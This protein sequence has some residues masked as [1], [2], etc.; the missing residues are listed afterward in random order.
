MNNIKIALIGGGGF[1]G[2]NLANY[3]T[4]KLFNVKIISKNPINIKNFIN[5]E[6]EEINLDVN[7]T[8][9]LINSLQ[10]CQ[11]IVWLVNELVPSST[12]NSVVDDFNFSTSS[13]I[14]FLEKS[15]NLK[16]L[17]RF[18]Y[19]SSGGTI[20][21]D[22][23]HNEDFA[24]I[25]L[26]APISAYGLSKRISE[27]YIEYFSR[28]VNYKCFV[29]RPSNV[30]G[31]FQNMNRMQGIIGFAFNSILKN[32]TID[33]F[34]GGKV[35][36]DFIYVEDLA[37]AIFAVIL[38]SYPTQIIETYNIASQKPTAIF[39]VL[40]LIENVTN[41]KLNI[42]HKPARP[43]DCTYNVLDISKITADTQWQP[44]TNLSEGLQIVWDWLKMEA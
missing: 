33:L 10:D 15:G 34:G 28:K 23:Q 39:E 29:L 40:H 18:I 21:G 44:Q 9:D 41:Q 20:Y 19:L 2:T 17:Q 30:Y 13:L 12:M 8:D 36:R 22:S 43:F 3:F 5:K 37:T 32:K 4:E 24:E 1:I 42:N 16:S 27:Q 7:R 38:K 6:I 26:K 35:Y 31:K 14:H 25:S 11:I